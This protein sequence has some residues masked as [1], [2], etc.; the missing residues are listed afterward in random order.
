MGGGVGL[1]GG[2]GRAVT[3]QGEPVQPEMA[4]ERFEILGKAGER[5]GA[6][7][8]GRRRGTGTATVRNDQ[9]VTGV[10][11]PEVGQVRGV[12]PGAGQ[13]DDRRPGGAGAAAARR[14]NAIGEFGAVV[15]GVVG[16]RPSLPDRSG[17][18]HGGNSGDSAGTPAGTVGRTG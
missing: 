14:Q 9:C 6:R 16:H 1:R 12:P 18:G 5:V 3:Q 4:A 17:R 2:G 7:V 15:R 13:A 10:E 11:G 8:G